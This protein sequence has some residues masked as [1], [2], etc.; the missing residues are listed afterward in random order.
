M[1]SGD[2][3]DDSGDAPRPSGRKDTSGARAREREPKRRSGTKG[4]PG[5]ALTLQNLQAVFGLSLQVCPYLVW[6][7]I[8]MVWSCHKRCKDVLTSMY[9]LGGLSSKRAAPV[10]C[11]TCAASET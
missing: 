11:K 7:E 2:D 6:H 1:A 8:M 9:S 3:G 10:L 4:K 5:K